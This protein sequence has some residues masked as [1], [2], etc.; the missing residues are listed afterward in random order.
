MLEQRFINVNIVAQNLMMN[1][2]RIAMNGYVDIK[3]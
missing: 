1:M 3:M 2:K